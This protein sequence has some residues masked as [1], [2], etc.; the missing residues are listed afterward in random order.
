MKSTAYSQKWFCTVS[1]N[2][3]AEKSPIPCE[4]WKYINRAVEYFF[5]TTPG[6]FKRMQARAAQGSEKQSYEDLE[7]E[8]A[9]IWNSTY[10][11][12]IERIIATSQTGIV[13]PAAM[14]EKY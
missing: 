3:Q 8:V 13:Q 11:L 7:N 12:S 10:E 4:D 2:L 14:V 5:S 9:D 6:V 1:R